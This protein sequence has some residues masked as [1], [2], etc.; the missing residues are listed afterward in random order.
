RERPRHIPG[1]VPERS[2]ERG[3]ERQR[4]PEL[5]SGAWI[6]DAGRNAQ[7]VRERDL[8]DVRPFCALEVALLLVRVPPQ[9]CDH[10]TAPPCGP[11]RNGGMEDRSER[12]PVGFGNEEVVRGLE[13]ERA[14]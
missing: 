9:R 11:R 6:V 5:I 7:R 4:L 13:R 3:L 1:R 10:Q 14:G 12:L 8:V 2:R